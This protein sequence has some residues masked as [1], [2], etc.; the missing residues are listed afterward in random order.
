MLDDINLMNS[1]SAKRP[2]DIPMQFWKN[3]KYIVSKL[4]AYLFTLLLKC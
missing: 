4:L 1:N 2:D 3:I